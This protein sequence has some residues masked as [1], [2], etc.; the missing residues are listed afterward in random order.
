MALILFLLSLFLLGAAHALEPGH[1]KLLVTSYLAGSQAKMRDAF[2]LGGL[3]A[4]FHTLSVALIAVVVVFLAMT[5]FKAAF[6]Q[7]LEVLSGTVILGLGLLLFW[8]RF[9][10]PRQQQEDQCDCHLLHS[11]SASAETQVPPKAT[12]KE[13]VLLGLASGLAPCPTALAAMIAAFSVGKSFTALGAL[14]VFSLGIGS[15]LVALGIILI[16][17]SSHLQA[18]WQHFREAPV[19]IGKVSTIIVILL[20]CYLVIKPFAFPEDEH[21]QQAKQLG[22]LS[23]LSFNDVLLKK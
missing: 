21:P 12:L 2:L 15:V 5:F 4:F 8:R 22:P 6:L 18:K 23:S 7:S 9:L 16:Q 17:G 14:V 1:G 10:V 20:G 11:E 13:V 3:V 19:L